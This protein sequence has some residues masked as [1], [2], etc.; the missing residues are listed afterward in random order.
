MFLSWP[1][2]SCQRVLHHGLLLVLII[3]LTLSS[4]TAQGSTDMFAAARASLEGKIPARELDIKL[5]DFLYKY[6]NWT[7]SPSDL[8]VDSVKRYKPRPIPRYRNLTTDEFSNL[9]AS[10]IPFILEDAA[11]PAWPIFKW[12]CSSF[13]KEFPNF[14]FR[15]EYSDAQNSGDESNLETFGASTGAPWWMQQR[16]NNFRNLPTGAPKYAP[17]YWDFAKGWETEADRGWLEQDARTPG[18]QVMSDKARSQK[19]KREA[20]AVQALAQLPR[21]MKQSNSNAEEAKHSLE[22]WLQPFESGSGAHIDGH[23]TSTIAFTFGAP[24]V[25]KRWRLQMLPPKPAPVRDAYKD[26]TVYRSN[27]WHHQWEGLVGHGEAIVFYPGIIHEGLNVSPEPIG[28]VDRDKK[29]DEQCIIGMTYQF[30]QPM[31]SAMYRHFIDRLSRTDELQH[32]RQESRAMAGMGMEMASF[33]KEKAARLKSAQQR[34]TDLDENGDGEI[35]EA[36]LQSFRSRNRGRQ[37]K[38]SRE[39][40]SWENILNF[41]DTDKDGRL[42]KDESTKAQM[43]FIQNELDLRAEN[44]RRKEKKAQKRRRKG[45]RTDL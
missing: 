7:A 23:C 41:F 5:D 25:Q 40:P 36:E 27:E 9:V 4:A 35:T 14:K 39:A 18:G 29:F 11:D 16:P 38:M 10:G 28:N 19:I 34:S 13:D 44:Q 20:E 42:S 6:Y 31:P 43:D 12:K 33:S 3:L 30:G 17:F 8:D 26:G 2:L 24:G 37:V 15:Q 1:R 22:F 21:C 32:C 45:P